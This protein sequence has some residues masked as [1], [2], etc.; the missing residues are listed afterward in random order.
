MKE[1]VKKLQS[2]AWKWQET[3]SGIDQNILY[4]AIKQIP[5]NLGG[6]VIHILT[7]LQVVSPIKKY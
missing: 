3:S 7:S 2:T 1:T 4:L 5:E 6:Q